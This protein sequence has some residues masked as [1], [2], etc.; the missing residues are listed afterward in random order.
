[1]I[2]QINDG[3]KEDFTIV[4]NPSNTYN[5]DIEKARIYGNTDG[6]EAIKQTVYHILNTERYEYIIYSWNYGVELWDLYGKPL[7]YVYS[8]IKRRI[9]EALIQDDRIDS[10][11]DFEFSNIKGAVLTSF[12][13]HSKMGDFEESKEVKV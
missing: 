1:M 11:S 10:V 9:T 8:E 7:P 5:H 2:P 13:V 4:E 6:L 3:L 12:T